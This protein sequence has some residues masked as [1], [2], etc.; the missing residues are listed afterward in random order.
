[1]IS[2]SL[3]LIVRSLEFIV[4][5]SSCLWAEFLDLP[6]RTLPVFGLLTTSS[7]RC[8]SSCSMSIINER[9]G[10]VEERRLRYHIFDDE[11]EPRQ[12]C[13]QYP[14]LPV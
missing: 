5:T 13:Q 11:S 4:R 7:G 8:S 10:R 6:R 1:M 12:P 14:I 9:N 2:S 3:S